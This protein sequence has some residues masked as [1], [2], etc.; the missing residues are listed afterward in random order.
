M[1][2]PSRPLNEVST[3]AAVYRNFIVGEDEAN[4]F[5]SNTISTSLYTPYNFVFKNLFKQFTRL[6]NVYF[7]FITILQVIPQVTLS[8]GYP[9]TIIPLM[10][11]LVVNSIKDLF[12]DIRR[13]RDDNLQNNSITRKVRN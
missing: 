12:E 11:V 7:L 8:S 9:T 2:R 1:S 3:S 13:H 10:F 6:S 4:R 5:C